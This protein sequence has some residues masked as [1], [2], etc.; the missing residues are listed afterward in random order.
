M[1][2]VLELSKQTSNVRRCNSAPPKEVEAL[3]HA[4]SNFSYFPASAPAIAAGILDEQKCI[5]LLQFN[6]QTHG[7]YQGSAAML[8]MQIATP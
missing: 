3:P 2:R 7:G 8:P 4:S 1:E 6:A 5:L